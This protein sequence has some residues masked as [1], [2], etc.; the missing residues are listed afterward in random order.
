MTFESVGLSYV[1]NGDY[2]FA[3]DKV[4]PREIG[5]KKWGLERESYVLHQKN[6]L[7]AY[8]EKGFNQEILI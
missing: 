3:K 4:G 8:D 5:H 6:V 7:V 1:F 2:P